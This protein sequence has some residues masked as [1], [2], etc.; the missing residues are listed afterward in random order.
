MKMDKPHFGRLEHMARYLDKLPPERFNYCT[1]ADRDE[2]GSVGC[3]IGHT[4]HV[5]PKIV[6]LSYLC[7]KLVGDSGLRISSYAHIGMAV[8]NVSLEES[9]E[10]FTPDTASKF[11]D[12]W[13]DGKAKPT[14]VARHIRRYIKWKKKEL[15]NAPV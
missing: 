5:F 9:L 1:S 14:E 4:T 7:P 3:A 11:S 2:C 10:L 6:K 12:I 15:K 13:L 8:F